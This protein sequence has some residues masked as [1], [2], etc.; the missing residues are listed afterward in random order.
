[1]ADTTNKLVGHN[2]TPPDLVAK[3]T[4]ASE[5]CGGLPGGGDAVHEAGS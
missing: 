3:V 5:V 4:G 2:Y 1:M